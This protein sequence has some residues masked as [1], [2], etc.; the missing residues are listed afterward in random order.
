MPRQNISRLVAVSRLVD[1]DRLVEIEAN[2]V[3]GEG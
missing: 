2:A 1:P 3:V